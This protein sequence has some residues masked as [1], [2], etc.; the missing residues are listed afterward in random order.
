MKPP[1]INRILQEIV[2]L[3]NNSLQQKLVR[4]PYIQDEVLKKLLSKAKRTEFG[5]HYDFR[6]ILKSRNLI[7][8]YRKKVPVFDYVKMKDEWWHHSLRG[9]MDISWPGKIQ[10][11]ALTSGTSDASS[12]YVPVSD[13]MIK[14]IRKTGTRQILSLPDLDISPEIYTKSILMLGGSSKLTN[15]LDYK[16]GDLSGIM[17]SKLPLWIQNFYKPG[18]KISDIKEWP[19]KID[20]IVRNA[21]Q[22]DIGII[23]GVPSWV[24]LLIQKVIEYYKVENIHK[25]W[26]NFSIY[27][28]GGVSF[29]PYE[30]SFDHLLGKKI[31][32]LETYL[33]SEGFFAIEKGKNKNAMELVLDIGVFYEFVPFNENNFDAN[34]VMRPNAEILSLNSVQTGIDYALLVST[35]SGAWR[36]QIG[37]TIRFTSISNFE[38]IVTGRT[39]HFLSICGEHLS[40]DNLDTAISKL[41]E[42][43]NLDVNEYGV[44]GQLTE[45]GVEHTWY[46]GSNGTAQAKSLLE[47]IDQ[48][49]IEINDDYATERKS[50]LKKLK[51]EILPLSTFYEFMKLNNK[52]GG[53]HKF[54]RVLKGTMLEKWNQYLKK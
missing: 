54:P 41:S 16:V 21:S 3:K 51:L 52:E 15:A 20:E 28:H 29:K 42:K 30:K 47:F 50:V 36:Y 25:V 5:K 27:V 2:K 1:P 24:Q 37:D 9:E 23:S 33:A 13:D 43:F 4:A 34:G 31:T 32:Y 11:F 22:W 39:K 35:C 38:I 53:Q 12:K 18:K 19:Q 8:S 49:L 40:I 26:P 7:E 10:Y 17:I 45:N 14:A 46:L 44:A 6:S 48:T